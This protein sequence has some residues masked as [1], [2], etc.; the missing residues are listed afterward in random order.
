VIAE[1]H[2][3]HKIQIIENYLMAIMH[4]SIIFFSSGFLYLTVDETKSHIDLDLLPFSQGQSFE[5]L[6]DYLLHLEALGVLG[7]SWYRLRPDGTYELVRRKP[8]FMP[9]MIFTRTELLKLYS[10]EE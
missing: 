10:F 4:L 5:K 6:D 1:N 8:P 7:I 3:S 2:F 9:A